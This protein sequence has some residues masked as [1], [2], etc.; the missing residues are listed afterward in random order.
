MDSLAARA[1]QR[2]Q[3]IEQESAPLFADTPPMTTIASAAGSA[4]VF[5][6]V[7]VRPIAGADSRVV[8]APAPSV[9]FEKRRRRF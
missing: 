4:A 8:A 5:D 2:P 9:S 3:P 1:N 7:L 6:Q